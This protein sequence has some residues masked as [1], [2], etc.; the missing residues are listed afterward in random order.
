[1]WHVYIVECENGKL[2]T[3]MTDNISRRLKEHRRHGSHFTSYNHAVK[4]LLKEPCKD[5]YAAAK[6][7]KQIKG[8]TQTKKL[9]LISNDISLLKQL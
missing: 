3:G 5:K 7:E 9:A 4:L 1:M 6:R 2:Y 8:W